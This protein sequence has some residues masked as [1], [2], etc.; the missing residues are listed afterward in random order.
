MAEF[1]ASTSADI[2]RPRRLSPA[3]PPLDRRGSPEST[4]RTHRYPELEVHDC[5]RRGR[6]PRH[7]G[8]RP[9]DIPLPV[10]FNDTLHH[11]YV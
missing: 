3:V 4:C 9:Y 8:L 10:V 2:H 1:N 6:V 11:T 7:G 5:P